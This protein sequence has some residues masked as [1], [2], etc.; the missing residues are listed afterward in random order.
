MKTKHIL[1]LLLAITSCTYSKAQYSNQYYHRIGDTVEWRNPICYYQ[2]WDAE[3]FYNDRLMFHI[4][5]SEYSQMFNGIRL[6]K[7]FSPD[8]MKVIGLCVMGWVGGSYPTYAQE[9]LYLYDA[10]NTDFVLK[11][12]VPWRQFHQ[13]SCRYLQVLQHDNNSIPGGQIVGDVM[14]CIDP[15]IRR[16]DSCCSSCTYRNVYQM[17]EYYFDTAVYVTDSFYVGGSS[18]SLS[19][20]AYGS[21]MGVGRHDAMTAFGTPHGKSCKEQGV[22]N[23]ESFDCNP[24]GMT[25]RM[26]REGFAYGL[27]DIPYHQ[28]TWRILN[29]YLLIVPIIQVDTTVPVWNYCPPVENVQVSL[30]EDSCLILTWDDCVNYSS[31]TVRYGVTPQGGTTQWHEIETEDNIF[32]LCGIDTLS[33]YRFTL[34]AHCDTSKQETDWSEELVYQYPV[35]HDVG[36]GDTPL[37]RHTHL[38]PNPAHESVVVNTGYTLRRIEV[39]NSRGILVYSEPAWGLTVTIDLTGWPSGSY[40]VVVGTQKGRTAKVLVKE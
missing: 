7:Y 15:A 30:V 8:T 20:G 36:T 16:L 12:I 27:F 31:V 35:R 29:E 6:C 19:G 14:P 23:G 26:W 24:Q 10:T 39:Y 38:V 21:Y 22:T 4:G 11:A 17:Y 18:F 3:Q 37:S 40:I 32:R 34:R 9:Y 5:P 1:F 13:D 25:Y 33:E 28:W 2:W